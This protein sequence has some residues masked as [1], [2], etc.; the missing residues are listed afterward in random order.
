MTALEHD[1]Q[2]S[3]PDENQPD[4]RDAS[5]PACQAMTGGDRT[6]EPMAL[7][8]PQIEARLAELDNLLKAGAYEYAAAAEAKVRSARERDTLIALAFRDAEGQPTERRQLAL[9]AVGNYGIEAE[10]TYARLAA[11]VETIEQRVIIGTS[12]LKAAGKGSG[13]DPRYRS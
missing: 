10:A 3:C 5:C 4:A 2:G 8:V 12:L 1:Y 7:T 11:E 9:A 6:I 13:E